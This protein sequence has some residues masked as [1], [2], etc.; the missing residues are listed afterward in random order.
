MHQLHIHKSNQWRLKIIWK[1][2]QVPKKQNLNFHLHLHCIY[3]VLG[4]IIIISSIQEDEHWLDANTV[5]L[6]TRDLSIQRFWDWKGV[7]QLVPP[8]KPRDDCTRTWMNLRNITV[9]ERIQS[10]ETTCSMLPFTWKSRS[11]KSTE[12]ESLRA[13]GGGQGGGFREEI[14]GKGFLLGEMRIF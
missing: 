14:K 5:P 12:T 8:E 7:L 11:E 4:T 10:Q 3:I 9:R 1:K 2:I 6:Y 13:W